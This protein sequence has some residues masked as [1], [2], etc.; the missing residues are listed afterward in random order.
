MLQT[1]W[2]QV[3]GRSGEQSTN[4]WGDDSPIEYLEQGI[5]KLLKSAT[6]TRYLVIDAL[7]QL[8]PRFQERL[9]G[10]LKTITQSCN[11]SLAISCRNSHQIGELQVKETFTIEVT[12]DRNRDDINKYLEKSLD[13]EF[14][15]RNSEL[16]KNIVDKL[17]IKAD[18]M[19]V[20]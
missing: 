18:G 13:S 7:D 10:W 8:P 2:D 12:T 19:L 3:V 5:Q 20:S 15:H 9:L 1:F 11:L 6:N 4:I 16:R 14:L 17:S